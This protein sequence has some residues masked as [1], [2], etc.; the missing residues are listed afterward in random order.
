[1]NKSNLS[2]QF[3]SQ[4]NSRNQVD[5]RIFLK[6]DRIV[7]QPR[8]HTF[9][10]GMNLHTNEYIAIRLN[11]VDEYMNDLLLT[12]PSMSKND[13]EMKARQTYIGSNSR[14]TLDQ[15]RDKRKA[16]FLSF[17]KCLPI[18]PIQDNLPTYR[19]HWS[20][21]M[22]S[23]PNTQVFEG[24]AYLKISKPVFNDKNIM[25]KKPFAN[26]NIIQ[27]KATLKLKDYAKNLSILQ[28]A[29]ATE[30]KNGM[31]R[32]G[33][34]IIEIIDTKNN[35]IIA[36]TYIFQKINKLSQFNS[37]SGSEYNISEP[38]SFEESLDDFINKKHEGDIN[39]FAVE[40]D[41][42]R[43]L[44]PLYFG[45]KCNKDSFCQNTDQFLNTLMEIYSA[46][47]NN[48]ITLNITCIHQVYLGVERTNYIINN[49][50]KGL[51]KAYNGTF[52]Q[53]GVTRNI[54]KY[55]P[56]VFALQFHTD[57]QRPYV[58]FNIISNKD[59]RL[60]IQPLHKIPNDLNGNKYKKLN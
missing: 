57:S 14:E 22:S 34:A 35:Q 7:S 9:A 50:N 3:I 10:Y 36:E 2:S 40:K 55:I 6:V 30:F 53:D 47:K 39:S 1:M 33:Y 25:I 29:L 21:L 8:N 43:V 11:S 24:L 13:A 44:M 56:T 41:F 51:I 17:D 60:N 26:L 54:R 37:I 4:A 52:I 12:N 19:S 15:K 16:L 32:T 31:S 18:Q 5:L 49:M 20:E 45:K 48:E 27:Q 42:L 38:A 59:Q 28:S 58:A 46:A 23:N